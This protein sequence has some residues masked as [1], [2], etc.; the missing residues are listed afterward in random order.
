[1]NML[2]EK[3]PA[4]VLKKRCVIRDMTEKRT[5]CLETISTFVS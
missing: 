4:F 2:V 1:M 5:V 3:R